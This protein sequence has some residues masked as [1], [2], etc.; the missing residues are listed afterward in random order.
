MEEEEATCP[1]KRQCTQQHQP[2]QGFAD[3]STVLVPQQPQHAQ[4]GPGQVLLELP[5][6]EHRKLNG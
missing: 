5:V 3:S 6:G 2:W 1:T 4:A